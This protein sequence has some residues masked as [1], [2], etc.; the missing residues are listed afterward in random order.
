MRGKGRAVRRRLLGFA[1]FALVLFSV[2]KV[3]ECAGAMAAGAH[4]VTHTAV[5]EAEGDAPVMAPAHGPTTQWCHHDAGHQ[6]K[7]ATSKQYA[8]P[9]RVADQAI[10]ALV[11]PQID[12]V[13]VPAAVRTVLL[14]VG[15][16]RRGPPGPD[17]RSSPS[18]R[19]LLISTCVARA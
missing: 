15:A 18:G 11:G 3:A 7:G 5:V 17:S 10:T 2:G 16:D 13:A 19:D 9:R 8:S 14:P 1:L 4:P 12:P 6:H